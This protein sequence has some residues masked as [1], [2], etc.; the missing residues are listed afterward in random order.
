MSKKPSFSVELRDTD[1]PNVQVWILEGKMMGGSSCYDFLDSVRD[2]VEEG[3]IYPVLDMTKVRFANSTSVGVL[4]SIFTAAKDAGGAIHLVG[5]NGRVESILK[6]IKL[7]YLVL[8]HDTMAEAMASIG[9][10]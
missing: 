8:V 9:V 10:D 4:A 2:N 7:W 5:V 1:Q 6:V 3:Q